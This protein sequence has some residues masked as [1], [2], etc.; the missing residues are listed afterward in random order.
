MAVD[1]GILVHHDAGK[2]AAEQHQALGEALP[3]FGAEDATRRLIL[4]QD[5]FHPPWGPQH[6]HAGPTGLINDPWLL[7]LLKYST[8]GERFKGF[9][10]AKRMDSPG[11][12]P[13]GRISRAIL[14]A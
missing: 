12:N 6:F 9:Y 1:I 4:T 7:I 5:I 11:P 13:L 8:I 10:E 2:A 3:G 14:G